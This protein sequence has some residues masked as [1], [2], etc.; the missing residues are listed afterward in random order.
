V[1]PDAAPQ[2]PLPADEQPT[3]V[4]TI[5]GDPAW[6]FSYDATFQNVLLAGAIVW[7]TASG[8]WAVLTDPEADGP[9]LLHIAATADTTPTPF[10]VPLLLS[11]DLAGLST[12][13]M[14]LTQ[15]VDG[16][17]VEYNVSG[18]LGTEQLMVTGFAGDTGLT[19]LNGTKCDFVVLAWMDSYQKE[20]LT[21]NPVPT[22]VPFGSSA[23]AAE[24]TARATLPTAPT[25]LPGRTASSS[26]A[27]SSTA[28]TPASSEPAVASSAAL[29]GSSTTPRPFV[30]RTR[31]QP[32]SVTQAFRVL[33]G[34]D[35]YVG[36]HVH[37]QYSLSLADEAI[38]QVA[39]FG[40]NPADW[41]LP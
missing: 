7:K 8:Y 34:I 41:Q 20:C 2:A 23:A 16:S 30:S 28:S 21:A 11:G 36:A 17:G 13:D 39:S 29:A 18:W 14:M 4:G 35:V 1:L 33:D 10:K 25:T 26:P 22:S 9:T 31:I 32:P 27:T 15:P 40:T 24:S 5:D 12:D 6:Y 38:A 3:R 19:V 37:E